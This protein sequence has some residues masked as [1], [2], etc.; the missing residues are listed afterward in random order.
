MNHLNALGL[1]MQK[2]LRPAGKPLIDL[3]EQRT[4]LDSNSRPE[5]PKAEIWNMLNIFV[6]L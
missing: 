1:R 5:E 2:S 6:S 4:A 3:I